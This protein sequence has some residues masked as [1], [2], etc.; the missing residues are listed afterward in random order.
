V[1][2]NWRNIFPI[3]KEV[4]HESESVRPQKCLSCVDLKME[5][6]VPREVARFE[7]HCKTLKDLYTGVVSYGEQSL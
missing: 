7:I 5:E 1:T 4:D 6:G 2:G 3:G